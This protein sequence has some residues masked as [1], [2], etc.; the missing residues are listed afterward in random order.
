MDSTAE[1]AS[2]RRPG[3]PVL[4]D[5]VTDALR[6]AY[7]QELAAVGYGK[8]SLEAIAR[9]AGTGKAAIYRRWASKQA[10][11]VELVSRVA[12][13]AV[14]VPDTGSLLGD[15]TGFVRDSLT[16]LS[17]PLVSRI[18]PDLLAEVARNGELA[19]TLLARVRDARRESAAQ[20]IHRGVERGELPADTDIELNLDFLAGPV[21]WRSVVIR[22]PVDEGYVDRVAAKIVAAME[23]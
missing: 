4:Q 12:V 16:V 21:Y 22:T 9:R 3:G 19:E 13:E 23:A 6:T 11:T 10:M 20:I 17:N 1:T 14:G 8:L 15:V 18:G 7:F 2:R 5:E